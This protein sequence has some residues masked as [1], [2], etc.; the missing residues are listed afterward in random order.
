MPAICQ[1]K[2]RPIHPAP[3]PASPTP[4]FPA[5]PQLNS[6]LLDQFDPAAVD[7]IEARQ[8]DLR[9]LFSAEAW[10]QFTTQV[11][12]YAFTAAQKMLESVITK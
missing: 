9:P 3:P 1:P 12:N 5:L 4:P 6:P 8:A 10:S 2:P 7:F 11:Q